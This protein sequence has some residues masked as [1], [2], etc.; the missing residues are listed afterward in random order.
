MFGTSSMQSQIALFAAAVFT[1]AFLIFLVQPMVGKQILPWFGGVPAVWMLCLC[2]YQ[3]ALLAGYGYAHLLVRRVQVR[4]QLVVH[5][6][7]FAAALVVLP[8]LPDATWKPAGGAPPGSHILWMLTANVALP[9][10][11]LAATG[12]L[13]QAWYARAFPGRSPYVLYAVSNAGSL[14][15]LLAYPFVVEPNL[16][17]SLTSRAWSSAFSICGFA[18]LGCAWIAT[19][20]ASAGDLLASEDRVGARDSA[21]AAGDV[22]LSIALPACAVVIF[23]GV[24]NELCLDTASVPLLW[25]VPLA[26]YLLSFVLC[27]G[28]PKIY[29]RAP[30]AVLSA[31]A[32]GGLIWLRFAWSGSLGSSAGALPIQLFAAAYLIALFLATLLLHGEVYRLRPPPARLTA[33]YLCIS[34]GGCLGGLFVGIAAP[35]IFDEYYELPLGWGACWLLFAY[36]CVRRPGPL[37]RRMALRRAFAAA[38]VFGV[39]VFAVATIQSTGVAQ[40]EL[41]HQERSFFNI[42]RVVENRPA[43]PA[44]HIV[45]LES[46]ATTHGAQLVQPNRRHVPTCYYGAG[47]GIGLVMARRPDEPMNVGVIGLGAGTLAAY[48]RSGDRYRFY[49]VDPEVARIAQDARYFTFLSESPA[50]IRVVLGDARLSLESEIGSEGS[51]EFDLLVLDAFTSDSIPVHL[52]TVEAFDLYLRHLKRDGVLAMHASSVNFDLVPLIMRQADAHDLGAVSVVNDRNL[53]EF[54]YRSKWVI[55]SANADYIEGF[56]AAIKE[57]R[58]ALGIRPRALFL[59]NPEPQQVSA[60]P[61][62][63]DDYSDLLS[64]LKKD[65]FERFW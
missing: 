61:L 38:V 39:G 57:N 49:E 10:L 22:F 65:F 34:G 59:V 18:I 62:W 24:T 8:V 48:G 7:V 16:S 52:L 45:R 55:L 63:T 26:I 46:G 43:N 51:R 12:P 53:R 21:T 31:A 19:R 5:A 58:R 9:F 35:E 25:V 60:A 47:T 33:Y 32:L 27:F 42:L 14:L 11:V 28:F 4:R 54:R 2:F 20:S 36:A 30:V 17:L 23:M 41:I 64:A 44:R 6:I 15:A 37:L 40:G 29:R 3:F 1:S 50:E 56:P 13:L